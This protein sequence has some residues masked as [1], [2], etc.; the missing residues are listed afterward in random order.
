M[1]HPVQGDDDNPFLERH[2][3]SR[4]RDPVV[5]VWRWQ[6]KKESSIGV[7]T[8]ELHTVEPARREGRRKDVAV[9]Y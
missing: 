9:L 3:Y 8:V 5:Q 4:D 1:D 6:E 2:A 7:K